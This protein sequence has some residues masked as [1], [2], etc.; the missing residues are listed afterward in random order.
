VVVAFSVIGFLVL[1]LIYFAVRHQNAQREL[2]QLR[3]MVK[4]LD[5][6]GKF[7]L[8]AVVMLSGQLQKTYQTRLEWLNKHA[9]ISATDYKPASF[10]VSQVEYVILQCCEQR[11]TVE[12]AINK[13]LEQS[14]L[15]IE[16]INQFVA[17]QSSEVRIPWCKNTIGGF[18]AACHNMTSESIKMKNR[19]P[20]LRQEKD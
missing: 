2:T 5:N 14:D 19:T 11:A 13:A 8:S 17:R 10:V 1:L 6:Q 3:R 9:L 18:L 16:S 12:E 7:S 15:D 20:D 4:S